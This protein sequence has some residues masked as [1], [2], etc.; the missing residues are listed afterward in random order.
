VSAAAQRSFWGWGREGAG[1]DAAQQQAIVRTLAARFAAGERTLAPAPRIEDIALPAARISP[2]AALAP[3][4]SDTPLDRA[5]HTWGKSYRDVVRGL[6]GDFSA[7]PD[8]VARPRDDDDVRA[9]LD[10]CGSHD[11]AAIPYGGGSSVVGGVE[12][13]VG[14]GWRG[15]VSLDTTRIAGVREVDVASRAARISG[16]TLGPD[17]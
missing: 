4:C 14:E 3:L 11:V 5:S 6:R 15:A 12:A 1:P 10:W 9:L 7:A 8:F 13:D 16:G 2:P 17:L